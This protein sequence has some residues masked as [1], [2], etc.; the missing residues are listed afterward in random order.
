MTRVA[1]T[2]DRFETVAT[3]YVEAGLTPVDLPCLRVEPA[4][5][6]VLDRARDQA[7]EADLLVLTS[8]R[9][10]V[11][12][13]PDREMPTV[14]VAAVGLSTAA[15]VEEHGGR[16]VARGASGLADLV[17]IA[18]QHLGEGVVAFPH[19]AGSGPGG[20]AELRR[21]CP[22]LVEEEVYRSL[23]IAP[24]TDAVD[25]VAFASPS[26]VRGWH[27]SRDLGRLIVGAIGPTT[28]AALTQWRRAD[29]V[30]ARPSH[31]ALAHALASYPPR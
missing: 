2:T 22:N 18:A 6:E 17:E 27:L 20:L 4:P 21:R 11:L 23:P 12:L 16:V 15:A 3:A 29:V 1:V 30:P 13:W 31:S 9:T 28:G 19:A 5:A 8:A 24:G 25:A 14:D 26:A 7:A 10:V